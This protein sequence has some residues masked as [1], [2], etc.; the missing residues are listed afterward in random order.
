MKR[1]LFLFSVL[2][3][4]VL[5]ITAASGCS[6]VAAVTGPPAYETRTISVGPGREVYFALPSLK[7][8]QTLEGYF[9]T[10]GGNNDIGFKIQGPSGGYLTNST[11]VT[12][13]HD[14]QFKIPQDG[15]YTLFFSNG[16][17]IVTSKVV[18]LSVRAY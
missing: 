15:P 1:L 14:F 12:G 7:V 5:A 8:G 6:A 9:V 11:R 13:R 18:T 10:D 4:S 3:L 2:S 16:F 17:S